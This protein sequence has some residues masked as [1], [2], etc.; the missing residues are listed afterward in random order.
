MRKNQLKALVWDEEALQSHEVW[1]VSLVWLQWEEVAMAVMLHVQWYWI[2]SGEF[3]APVE[4][5]GCLGELVKT[6]T[7][8][9]LPLIVAPPHI[10]ALCVG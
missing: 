3:Q 1:V 6:W 2:M 8:V 4:E 5:E 9:I 10:H 7:D